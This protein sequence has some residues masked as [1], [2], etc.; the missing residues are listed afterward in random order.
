ML[1]EGT[2]QLDLY[3]F[4][5][6]FLPGGT[7][8][9]GLLPLAPATSITLSPGLLLFL[10][11]PGFVVGRGVHAF[12]LWVG[13]VVGVQTH[14]QQFIDEL[15]D[16]SIVT[17]EYSE[18]FFSVC[19]DT[20]DGLTLPEEHTEL[21]EEEHREILDDLYGLVRAYIHMDSRGRSRTFQ[22]VLDFHRSM[23]II[24][25][26]LWAVYFLYSFL[27]AFRIFRG[28]VTY[29]SYISALNIHFVIIFGVSLLILGGAYMTFKRVIPSYRQY[30]IQYM[31]ADF[32]ILQLS[33]G[34]IEEKRME[35]EQEESA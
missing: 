14:R 31:M 16:P 26:F 4:F 24:S 34:T 23:W 33:G 25:V 18:R 10:L 11:I 9:I 2:R 12:G 1:T 21:D 32:L 6:I 17:D 35:K 19:K 15:V 7:L 29:I 13:S 30:F 20:F 22:A 5:S 27:K 8:L 3:D 28:D